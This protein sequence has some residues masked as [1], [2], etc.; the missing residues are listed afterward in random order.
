MKPT[1]TVPVAAAACPAGRRSALAGALAGLL[2]LVVAPDRAPA[3]AGPPHPPIHALDRLQFREAKT[4]PADK[5]GGHGDAAVTSDN[6]DMQHY[7]LDLTIDPD[8]QYIAGS[9][10]MVFASRVA[11]LQEMVFDLASTL[12]V[13][14]I[15]HLSGDLVFTHA[16]DSVAVVLPAALATG[17]VDSV[18]VVY[19]GVP[20][21]PLYNY[22][23]IF[24]RHN[25]GAGSDP[26]DEGPIVA[27]LSEPAYAQS[28]WPCKDKPGDKATSSVTLHVPLDIVAVSNGTLAAVTDEG[29]G[30]QSYRWWES[31][32]I[33]PYL[34]SVAI[35]DYTLLQQ[36]CSTTLTASIP[37]RNWVFPPDAADAAVDFAPL[38][39]MI[40]FCES[41]YGPYP[42]QGEKYGHAE[43][44]W[45]GAMEHQTVTSIGQASIDGDGQHDWMIVHELG[46]QWFGDSLTPAT[47]AD[48]WLNEGFATYTEA[49]WVE[50]NEGAAA[51]RQYLI[52]SIDYGMWER[53]GPVYDPMPVFPG[54]VIYD[55][56]A[57]IVHML[58]GRLG[59]AAFFT[60]LHDWTNEDGRPLATVTTEAFVDLAG[61]AAGE[62]LTAFFDPWLNSTAIPQIVF[63]YGVDDPESGPADSRL[64][65][66]LRQVQTPL[67]D[68]IFPVRITTTAGVVDRTVR[69]D[70]AT[71]SATWDLGAAVTDVALDPDRW[72]LWQAAP[73]TGDGNRIT[74]IYPNP[75]RGY[76]YIRYHLDAE[77][78]VRVRIYDAY[79]HEVYLHDLGRVLP[80]SGFNETVW[81]LRDGRDAAVASGVYWVTVEIDGQRS[82]RKMAVIH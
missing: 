66:D 69:L 40:D 65:V 51:Y 17:E 20:T 35:S 41:V 74:L 14:R 34:I 55:K 23:L 52:D 59:D 71:A 78:A 81:D 36:E 24:R 42:F 2:L 6:Y 31:Y 60:L 56:G 67:F 32:P 27:N 3:A 77:A 61:A 11:G 45:P 22:G 43:F 15:E 18:R 5:D 8:V 29:G 76:A 44:L 73:G 39:D 62:D 58:R 75:A 49:L 16:A 1:I 33:A 70:E 64:R 37:L 80:D 25:A 82:V 38:C 9:V 13:Q 26:E 7:D 72:L 28:W 48:I 12:T 50:H 68:N 47:W 21:P 19:E 53:Q 63:Q 54:R 46:H 4:L 57:W 30:W 10:N 79:G